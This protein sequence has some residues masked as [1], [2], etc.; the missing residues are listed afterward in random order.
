MDY[1]QILGVSRSASKEEIRKAYRKLAHKYHPDKGGD[2]KKF[3][4]INEAYQVLFNDEKRDQYDRFGQV[5]G[6]KMGA[7][8]EQGFDPSWFQGRP[9]MDFDFG[10]GD[11]GDIFEQFFG[12]FGKTE[13]RDLKRGKDIQIDIEI[14]LE[15]VFN[16][17]E[18]EIFLR[19][20]ITCSRCQGKGAEPGSL[21]NECFSCRGT[22]QVQQIKRIF[23][24]S[25][26]RY[27]IC[28]E[29]KGE[30]QKPEKPCNVCKG[31]GRTE[32]QENVKLFI[33]RG[34]DSNQVIRIDKKGDA[35]RRGG[36]AG[37]LYVRI[38]VKKHP[39]FQRK[40]DDLYLQ[41]PISFS[42]AVLGD[43][44][45]ISS[46]EKSKILL[47]IPAGTESG[48]VLRISNKGIP[49]F[50]GYGRGGLYVELIIKTPRKLSRKQKELLEQLRK[51]GL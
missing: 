9:E 42:Q 29:C 21:I 2:E 14:S 45:E 7:G 41:T 12:K 20:M 44:I 35:G 48:K 13:K 28:P 17:T 49:H 50:S 36:R 46:L 6:E 16:G 30:G 8:Q 47:K 27:I 15:E 10:A 51:Q 38:F 3:K 24:G 37:D 4:E 23:F 1:Y 11:F 39:V 18:R 33:P 22:G 43:E 26:T 40:G 19:K 32:G 31:E 5:F 25:F 34:V